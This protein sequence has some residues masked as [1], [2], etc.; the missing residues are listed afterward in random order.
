VAEPRKAFLDANI[1]RGQLTTDTLLSLAHARLFEPRWS[2]PVLEE[3]R[4]NRPAG[5]LES[6]IDSRCAQMNKIFPAAMTSGYEP[7]M[8]Q[9]R[10]DEKDKHV[11]AAAVLSGAD[12]A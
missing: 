2:E 3:V 8:P 9:M 5:V 10:A 6:S 1:L 4:R 7:L 11:L 12:G